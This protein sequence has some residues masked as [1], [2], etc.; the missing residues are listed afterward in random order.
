[1]IQI[2]IGSVSQSDHSAPKKQMFSGWSDPDQKYFLNHSFAD[3][4]E[5]YF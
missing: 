5:F 3:M 4:N 2:K 1:M